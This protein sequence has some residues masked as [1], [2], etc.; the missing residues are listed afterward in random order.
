M[1][2][3]A[4]GGVFVSNN[5]NVTITDSQI[6]DNTGTR[7]GGIYTE[8]STVE[9]KDSKIDGNTADD[10]PEKAPNSNKGLGGGIYSF[11]STLTVTD[12]T[13]SGNEA[14]GS[15]STIIYNDGELSSSTLGNGGGGI[16]AVGKKSDVTLDK[17]T[18]TGNKATSNVSTNLVPAAAL[19]PRAA[20]SPLRIPPSATTTPGATAAVSSPHRAT[21]WMSRILPSRATRAITAAASTR[22]KPVTLLKR[23]PRP[24]LPIPRS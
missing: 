7:G 24:P 18:V 9:V 20:A 10:V 12:S 21:C 15:T 1:S 11:D 4:G 16:C 2:L 23:L 13:I 6:L 22:V 5:S 19:K 3:G 14:K 8:H 17:V